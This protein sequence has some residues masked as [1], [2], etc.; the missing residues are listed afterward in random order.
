MCP[1]SI[2]LAAQAKEGSSR[3]QA[4]AAPNYMNIMLLEW[5]IFIYFISTRSIHQPKNTS[6]TLKYL[7]IQT[8]Y[9]NTKSCFP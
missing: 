9:Y 2:F 4:K 1:V 5:L 3:F 8:L 6:H 7:K